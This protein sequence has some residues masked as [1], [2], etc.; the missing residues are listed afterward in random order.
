[1]GRLFWVLT[2]LLAL[3]IA[4]GLAFAIGVMLSVL[5]AAKAH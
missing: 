3:L 2:V 5:L 4:A 1:V